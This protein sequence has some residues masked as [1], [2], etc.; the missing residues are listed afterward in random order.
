[1][2]GPLDTQADNGRESPRKLKILV[3]DRDGAF[4]SPTVT[5]IYLA[6]RI[7]ELPMQEDDIKVETSDEFNPEILHE[8]TGA[9]LHD[10][11]TLDL[12]NLV[13]FL[14]RN[15]QKASNIVLE[16]T[17]ASAP[18]Q[19]ALYKVLGEMGIKVLYRPILYR[20]EVNNVLLGIEG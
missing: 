7:N 3:R 11:S 1:M 2:N 10:M 18:E 9:L 19:R 16:A 5:N 14:E 15:P 17:Y 13:L 12:Q 8:Y 20:D 4:T 6:A